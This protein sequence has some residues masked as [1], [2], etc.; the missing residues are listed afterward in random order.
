MWA[1]EV[2]RKNKRRSTPFPCFPVKL[3]AFLL[4]CE[5]SAA[6][7]RN[8]D[9]EKNP[10][11]QLIWS[12]ETKI[13]PQYKQHSIHTCISNIY[14]NRVIYFNLN[15][16]VRK[17]MQITVWRARLIFFCRKFSQQTHFRFHVASTWNPRGAFVGL[18]VF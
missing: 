14:R 10:Y 17:G 15:W 5:L 13:H 4:S 2:I 8:P 6:M 9:R 18:K 16:Q 1:L 7:K 12:Y 3:S 11:L